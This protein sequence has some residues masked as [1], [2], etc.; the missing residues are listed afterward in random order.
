MP[1][2]KCDFFSK[3]VYFKRR[4]VLSTSTCQTNAHAIKGEIFGDLMSQINDVILND[5]IFKRRGV[6]STSTC[7]SHANAIKRCDLW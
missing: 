6:L 2:K 4:R 5:R 3:L 1:Y 7:G